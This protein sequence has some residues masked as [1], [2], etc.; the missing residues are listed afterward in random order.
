MGDVVVTDM[1]EGM[2]DAQGDIAPGEI[3]KYLI[4]QS[5]EDNEKAN[6]IKEN[7]RLKKIGVI[8]RHAV[9][10]GG[11]SPGGGVGLEIPRLRPPCPNCV[12]P[13]AG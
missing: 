1:N 12:K 10:K 13:G 7:R 2:H 8:A 4:G 5:G 11:L 6:E 9:G 3:E